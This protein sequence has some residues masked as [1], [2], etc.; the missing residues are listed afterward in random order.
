MRFA[1][2]QQMMLIIGNFDRSIATLP[3]KCSCGDGKMN[4]QEKSR[5]KKV[6]PSTGDAATIN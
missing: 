5:N 6:V 2:I 1:S 3:L 4:R